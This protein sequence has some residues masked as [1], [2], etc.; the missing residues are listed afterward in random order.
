MANTWDY[1]WFGFHAWGWHLTNLL[2]HA[3]AAVMLFLLLEKLFAHFAVPRATLLASAVATIWAI[4]PLHSAAVIY[5]SG[6]ADLI[7]AFFGFAGLYLAMGRSSLSLISGAACLLAAM[8]SKESGC[9]ASLL[10]MCIPFFNKRK[11][12]PMLLALICIAGIYGAL[13][14]TA[15]HET[16]P[17]PPTAIAAAARPILI[18]RAWAEYAGLLLAPA[19]LHMER[20]VLPFGRGDANATLR[21]AELREFQSLLGVLLMAAFYFWMRWTRRRELC[22]FFC[23]AAF[24]IAYLPVSNLLRLNATVAEHWLYFPSAFLFAG[25]ALSLTH[26]RLSKSAGWALL[27]AWAAFL[28]TRTFTRNF[29]WRD[30][31]TFL[32]RTIADGGDSAR[33]LINLGQLESAQGHQ[34]VAEAYF[35]TALQRAPEQPLGLLGLGAVYLRENNFEKAQDAFEKA[36]RIPLTRSEA[37]QDLAILEYKQ[38]GRDRVDLLAEAAQSAP[39]DWSIQKRYIGHLIERR[40][41]K[42]AILALQKVL[43]TQWWRSDSWHLLGDL[44]LHAHQPDSALRAYRHAAEFDVHDD[45]ARQ[46]VATIDAAFH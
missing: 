32:E 43:T 27:L 45:G 7:A 11:P 14:F 26:P 9:V 30:Q 20:D 25:A 46:Q 29:D 15:E 5:V 13:R 37:I 24:V 8:L 19:H 17:P 35:V 12:W 18:A 2:L 3:A 41:L 21:S 31:R 36:A 42:P 33:M 16:P 22:A 39:N 1:A 40:E 38:T 23:L 44:W 34:R 6:R 28:A 4:H 10:A